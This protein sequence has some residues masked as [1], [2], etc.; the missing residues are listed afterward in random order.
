MSQALQA[1]G[2]GDQLSIKG[3]DGLV[4]RGKW[5]GVMSPQPQPAGVH[6]TASGFWHRTESVLSIW[7]LQM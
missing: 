1:G 5:D 7:V 3:V 4:W 2:T 6:E